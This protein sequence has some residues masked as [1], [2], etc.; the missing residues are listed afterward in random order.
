MKEKIEKLKKKVEKLAKYLNEIQKELVNDV[1]SKEL[2]DDQL[3]IIVD[4]IEKKEK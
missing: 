1:Q 3:V 4:K 2:K